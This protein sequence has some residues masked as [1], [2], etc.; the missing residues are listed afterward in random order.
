M[1]FG[2]K[3]ELCH[4]FGF[5]GG[6]IDGFLFGKFLPFTLKRGRNLNNYIILASI[7]VWQSYFT[8]T[9]CQI[10]LTL[11]CR[12]FNF[13]AIYTLF[14]SKIVSAETLLV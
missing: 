4:H 14:F 1:V 7:D 5:F 2:C 12:Q 3:I 8:H 10:H 9:C 13:V 11:V 6:N